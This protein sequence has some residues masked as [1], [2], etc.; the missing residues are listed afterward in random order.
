M[1]VVLQFDYLPQTRI[2]S[3]TVER[4]SGISLVTLDMG[5]IFNE[6]VTMRSWGVD[7]V[8]MLL[9]NVTRPSAIIGNVNIREM[10]ILVQALERRV[11]HLHDDVTWQQ[12]Y[13][14]NAFP[15]TIH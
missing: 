5:Y 12:L 7:L 3:T 1:V 2:F 10:F 14:V 8:P 4:I 15:S 6:C 13:Q 9:C 11:G